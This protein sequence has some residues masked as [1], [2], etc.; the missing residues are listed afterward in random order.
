MT[1]IVTVTIDNTPIEVLFYDENTLEAQAKAL[2]AVAAQEAAEVALNATELARDQ[3]AD[4]V[5]PANIFIDVSL[6]TAEAAV[7]TGTTFKL[8]DS[9]SG[10][11]DVRKRTVGGSDLL[12]QEATL[13]ALEADAG[14]RK[15]G[16]AQVGT[17]AS[18]ETLEDAGQRTVFAQ[19]FGTAQQALAELVTRGGDTLNI[20]RGTAGPIDISTRTINVRGKGIGASIIEPATDSG[21]AIRYTSTEGSWRPVVVADLQ[22][23]GTGTLQGQGFR[24]GPDSY[25]A[26][27]E[28]VGRTILERM[29]FNN[30]DKC[31][32][33]PFGNIGMWVNES[34]F[35]G[36]NYHFHF[37][38]SDGTDGDLMHSGNYGITNCHMIGAEKAVLYMR[39]DVQGT[40]QATFFNDIPEYNPG[41]VF[42]IDG[43]STVGG[44]GLNVFNTW[45]E[46]NYTAPSVTIG[47]HTAA[48]VF[49]ELRRAEACYFHDTQV[50]P[51][52]LTKSCVVT[53]QSEMNLLTSV[54]TDADSTIIHRDARC[55]SGTVK[56]LVMS[57]GGVAASPAALNAG[58]FPMPV[59]RTL[60]TNMSNLVRGFSGQ[61]AIAF[62]G[63]TNRN[64]S[65]V[66]NDPALPAPFNRTQELTIN[67]GET[68][69]PTATFTIPAGKWLVWQYIARIRS[70]PAIQVQITGN[71]GIG[72]TLTISGSNWRMYT[73]IIKNAGADITGESF[74]HY[75]GGATTVLGI[76]GIGLLSF[77]AAQE[78]LA[79]ANSGAFI[80]DN[81]VTV[82]SASTIILPTGFDVIPVTGSTNITSISASGADKGRRV[83]LVFEGVLTLVNGSN[84]KLG[85]DITTAAF[86]GTT[87]VC[88]GTNWIKA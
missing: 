37:T 9:S 51:F 31:V 6:G 56:G 17:G 86:S 81:S 72:G 88:D 35:G 36:S 7:A 43:L 58:S 39:G 23:Q 79:Y 68:L 15:I 34:D 60:R 74:Y 25:A 42:Y 49:A 45:N 52:R 57:L 69:L 59:P 83:T 16:F 62:T 21:V 26:N 12:Y 64:S 77:D 11:A 29:R 2:Q 85:A 78:A 82:A 53:N 28:Y 63:T 8:V 27:A 71:A 61:T 13:A 54:E 40:G 41:Y 76:A 70:G 48:P 50:G 1:D 46:G 55:F 80:Y 33:R 4:L 10:L 18:A 66:N 14:A 30:L 75:H 20:D 32:V 3:A 73:A 67:S 44:P 47:A 24:C 5:D 22:V 19:Q 38:D 65:D 84:L 87:L